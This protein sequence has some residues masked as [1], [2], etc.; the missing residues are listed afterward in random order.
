MVRNWVVQDVVSGNPAIGC[1]QAG[2]N[3]DVLDSE[4]LKS[5]TRAGRVYE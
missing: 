4:D 3:S 1:M 2:E 5:E